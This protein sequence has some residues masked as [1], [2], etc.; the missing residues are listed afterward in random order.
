M[1]YQIFYI[2]LHYY[3]SLGFDSKH[4]ITFKTFTCTTDRWA[5]IGRTDVLKMLLQTAGI[6]YHAWDSLILLVRPM[7]RINK[8]IRLRWILWKRYLRSEPVGYISFGECYQN[9]HN[10]S[11]TVLQLIKNYSLGIHARGL[12]TLRGKRERACTRRVW[13]VSKVIARWNN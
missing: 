7:T 3:C 1:R 5:Q 10:W 9:Q 2:T 12:H 13:V 11:A 8:I 6:I 4:R